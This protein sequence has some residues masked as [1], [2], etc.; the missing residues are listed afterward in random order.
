MA[1]PRRRILVAAALSTTAL[2]AIGPASALAE[3]PSPQLVI[4]P[5]P[6]VIGPIAAPLGG[7]G[8]KLQGAVVSFDASGSTDPDGGAIVK[9][10]FDLDGD[11]AYERDNGADPTT[12]RLYSAAGTYVIKMRITDDQGE[13]QL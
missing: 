9:Y 4:S 1:I 12:S 7:G 11:G 10:E 6:A 5:A 8:G 13:S 3:R 2:A